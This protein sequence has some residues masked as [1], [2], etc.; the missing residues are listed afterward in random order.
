MMTPVLRNL[1]ASPV[2]LLVIDKPKQ[3]TGASLLAN[4]IAII[5]T[6]EPAYM[7]TQPE[8][9]EKENEW[10]KRTTSLVLD[11]RQIVVIDN[12]E[13][14]LRSPTLCAL[15]TSTTWSDRIFRTQ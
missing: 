13:G 11:G 9:R 3:G 15:L 12:V 1:I 7:T 8:G 5:A 10:R 4:T 6:G 2:P 14:V